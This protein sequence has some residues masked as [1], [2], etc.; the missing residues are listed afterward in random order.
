[1]VKKL[2]CLLCIFLVVFTLCAKGGDD[3]DGD[4]CGLFYDVMYAKNI[5]DSSKNMEALCY[6]AYLSLDYN[7]NSNHAEKGKKAYNCLTNDLR[8]FFNF[9]QKDLHLTGDGGS[10][11]EK[12]SHKGWE[13]YSKYDTTTYSKWLLRK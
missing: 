12:V 3:H 7:S 1:M 8:L 6:A 2:I 9:T 10:D 11:H 4:L 13:P 5:K